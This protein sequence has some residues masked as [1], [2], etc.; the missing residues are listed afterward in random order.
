MDGAEQ[1]FRTEYRLG[2]FLFYTC[3]LA[4]PVVTAATAI[5]KHSALW[6]ILFLLLSAGGLQSLQSM[7]ISTGLPFTVVLLIMC[8]AIWKGLL[9]ERRAL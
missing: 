8:W 9:A 4:V 5:L 3:L 6:T 1:N 7:V 2:D